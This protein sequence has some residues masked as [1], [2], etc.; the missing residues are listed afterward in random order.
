MK[1][2][3]ISV[4][5]LVL[6]AA[7]HIHPQSQSNVPSFSSYVIT[8]FTADN[9]LPQNTVDLVTQ[10]SD[11]YIWIGT[12]AGL[13]RYDGIK[14]IHF[15]K[16]ITPAFKI[17]HVTTLI[18]DKSGTVW[19][20]TNG[21]GI[22]RYSQHAFTSITEIGGKG[23][24]FIKTFLYDGNDNILVGTERGGIH[25]MV[26][27]E[28]GNLL[29]VTPYTTADLPESFLLRSIV[30]DKLNRILLATDIGL[31]II[32][33]G[34]SRTL[35]TENGLLSNSITALAVDQNNVIW[36]GTANGLIRIQEEKIQTFTTANGITSNAV[37]TLFVDKDNILWIGT[38]GGGI[39]RF[40][41]GSSSRNFDA[42]T[43]DDGLVNNF[44]RTIF[45][46]SENNIWIGTRNGLSQVHIRKFELFGKKAG[47]SDSYVRT[48]FEDSKKRIWVGTNGNGLNRLDENGVKIWNSEKELPNKFIRT[49][50]EDPDGILWIGTD[51]GGVFKFDERKKQG[52][53]FSR[54]TTEQGLT[55]NY[56]RSIQPGFENDVWVATYGGGISRI[57]GDSVIPF[58][59]K[60]GL[61]NDNVLAMVRTSNN[62]MWVGTNGGG[63]DKITPGGITRF[64]TENG[65]S[66]NF[67]LSL[68]VD[69]DGVA[70]AGTN[71]GGINRISGS[72]VQVFTTQHGLR[73]DVTLMMIEDNNGYVWIGGNQGITRIKK[74]DFQDIVDVKILRLPKIDFGRSDGL[75]NAEI[76]GVSSPCIIRSQ[77]G[78]IWFTTVG[79]LARV[80]PNRL[81]EELSVMPLHIEEIRVGNRT[82][83]PDSLVTIE[84]GNNSIEFH[85]TSLS[86]VAPERIRFRYKLI[87]FN[88]EWVD[89][90]TRRAAYFTNL[91]P[92]TYTFT[93]S[94]STDDGTWSERQAAVTIIVEPFFYQTTF[95]IVIVGLGLVIAG[96]G[97]YALRTNN[98]HRHARHLK[99]EV[100]ERTRDLVA[101][102]EKIE[103]HLMEVETARDE[104]ARSNGRLDKANKEKSDLLGILSHDFKN[105]VVNLNQFA[106]TINEESQKSGAVKEHA[107]LMEQTTQ[108]MLRL[109]EDTL[110]SSALEKGELVF[111]KARVDI[112]QLTELV[113]LK[114]RIQ[115]QQKS[116]SIEFT[117]SAEKCIVSGS[118]RWLNEAIDNL[119]NNAGKFSKPETT[120]T[121]SVDVGETA[122]VLKVKDQGPGLTDDDKQL[123]FQQFKRL[124]A[125]PTGGEISTG[126]GLAIVQKIITMHNGKV[127]AESVLGEG[128]TFVIELPIYRPI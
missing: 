99:T 69:K 95:F 38:D 59:T 77:D 56:I 123:L 29:S 107:Q 89:A 54:I 103:E 5:S 98:V 100:E 84:A 102:K 115:V 121:L 93:V 106:R 33:N 25:K 52:S 13:A 41:G 101:A 104:L 16:S 114:N 74:S 124:T 109:I 64:T 73:E 42:L 80:D 53:Q 19:I 18:E 10:T 108:Y 4:V 86:Y 110:S 31:I 92:G 6:L 40:L 83:Y 49:L 50:Y 14:F 122:V 39:N 94:T 27:D 62:E 111:T 72:D 1:K 113:V 60:Q 48:V 76:S 34:R 70:W 65:L 47:L 71:G 96:A 120:I 126:L 67:I 118:E 85:Y 26:A 3:F 105:K 82:F 91:Q 58:T 119:V 24:E 43:T 9:G 32:D 79:G 17:N 21:G 75:Q 22:V 35:T 116:Q 28:Q 97:L 7:S 46:D 87:G 45:Q 78:K 15:N 117:A 61:A 128:S 30:R 81:V 125:Q 20:G 12:Y 37:R 112:V 90:G 88:D 57:K 44:I 66:N 36:V 51:G 63:I 23:T 8:N 68:F 127:W 2:S 11:G 55:E